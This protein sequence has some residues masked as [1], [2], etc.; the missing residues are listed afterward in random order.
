MKSMALSSLYLRRKGLNHVYYLS[1]AP[2]L[3]RLF[4]SLSLPTFFSPQCSIH[5][6]GLQRFWAAEENRRAEAERT[7]GE[8]EG[9]GWETG[10]GSGHEE[11]RQIGSEGGQTSSRFK[12]FYFFPPPIL[13]CLTVIF[14]LSWL[15]SVVEF[16]T[17]WCQTCTPSSRTIQ[18][19]QRPPKDGDLLMK[20]T[21]K[22]PSALGQIKLMLIIYKQNEILILC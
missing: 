14:T 22:G 17:L 12:I 11:V 20:M 16:L 9:T 15:F 21:M 4:P 1:Y 18:L 8:K 2:H 5:A 13:M 6:A 3:A 7:R 19:E 10:H